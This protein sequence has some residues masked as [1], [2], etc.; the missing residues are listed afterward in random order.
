LTIYA[1]EDDLTRVLSSLQ[2]R[3]NKAKSGN[4]ALRSKDVNDDEKKKKTQQEEDI[5]HCE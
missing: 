3:S 5:R 4:A 2:Y 1:D